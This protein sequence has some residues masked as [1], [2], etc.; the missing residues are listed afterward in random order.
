[1][2]G[3]DGRAVLTHQHPAQASNISIQRGLRELG[4]GHVEAIGLQALDDR[5]PTRPVGPR[6]VDKDD[7][8]CAIW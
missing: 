2:A 5:A 8:K 4:S 6:A 1:M 7:M 3:D